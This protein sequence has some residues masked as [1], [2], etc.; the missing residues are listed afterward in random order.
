VDAMNVFYYLTY[1]GRCDLAELREETRAAFIEQVFGNRAARLTLQ[2]LQF[3]QTPTQ[4]LTGPHPKRDSLPTPAR[5][6]ERDVA[7]T[8]ASNTGTPIAFI[9][10]AYPLLVS[11]DSQQI[12]QTFRMSQKSPGVISPLLT[13]VH[14]GEPLE[15]SVTVS[16]RCFAVNEGVV[17][18]CGFCDHSIRCFSAENGLLLQSVYGHSDVVLCIAVSE[19]GRY[20]AAGSRDSTVSVWDVVKASRAGGILSANP[21]AILVG[22]FRPVISVAIR[23]NCDTV[24]SVSLDSVLLHTISG[25]F[26][27]PLQHPTCRR[28]YIACLSPDGDGVVY[29][30]DKAA[31]TIAV[32]TINGRLL[33]EAS[34]SEMLM[35]VV[36]VADGRHVLHGG[37]GRTAVSRRVWDLAVTGTFAC[38]S[39]IRS[40]ALLDS[41]TLLLGLASGELL[42]RACG[43]ALGTSA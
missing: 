35:D 15:Q 22:H 24:I 3:G 11:I 13:S 4:L 28:P 17:F 25:D 27:R 14:M 23:S 2:I 40:I 36:M 30:C 31:T 37:T 9:Y 20:L 34:L 29:Y 32:F 42:R 39:S 8:I 7:A 5:P 33:A 19:C 10:A 26:V 38:A 18:A 6:L 41:D 43:M 12:M 21:R 16:P 1:E